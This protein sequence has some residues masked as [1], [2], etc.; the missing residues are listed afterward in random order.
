MKKKI[1]D[2]GKPMNKIE[3][4]EKEE[5]K[6]KEKKEEEKMKNKFLYLGKIANFRFSQILPKKQK[7]LVKFT[8]PLM[9]SIIRESGIQRE[10]MKYSDFKNALENKR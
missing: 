4:E 1:G 5:K 8:S 7:V 6:E 3:K 10:V 2:N 9:E